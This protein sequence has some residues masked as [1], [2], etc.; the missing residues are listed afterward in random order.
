LKIPDIGISHLDSIPGEWFENFKEAVQDDNVEL[1]IE[2]REDGGAWACAEWFM[3]PAIAA[4]IAKSYFDGALNELGKEHYFKLK[5][6]LSSM[7]K[8][9]MAKP[10]IEPF[11]VSTP[12]KVNP[13]NPYSLAFA[14][15]AQTNDGRVIKLLLPKQDMNIDYEEIVSNFLDFLERYYSGVASLE[16]VG[17]DVGLSP[18]EKTIFVHMN[19]E[20]KEIEWLDHRN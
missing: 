11:I 14:I 2:S 20:T 5:R 9:V 3:I 1:V 12:G 6:A 8:E 18:R 15:H 7:A 4:Y 13:D 19:L 17:C 16:S 10:K